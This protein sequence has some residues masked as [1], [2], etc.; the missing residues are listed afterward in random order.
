M[1]NSIFLGK[2]RGHYPISMYKLVYSANN[3]N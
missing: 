2:T 1:Q 3:L